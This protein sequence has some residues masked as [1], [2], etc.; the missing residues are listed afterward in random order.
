MTYPPG[1]PNNPP[2]QPP[3]YGQQP[4]VWPY[5]G[6][7]PRKGNKLPFIVAAAV[8]VVAAAILIPVLV[9][10]GTSES[11]NPSVQNVASRFYLGLK[12]HNLSTLQKLGCTPAAVNV[13]DPRGLKLITN[14]TPDRDPV[15][16]D[17]TAAS[18]GM[19]TVTSNGQSS[20]FPISIAYRLTN[21]N[22]CIE[23]VKSGTASA[24]APSSSSSHSLPSGSSSASTASPTCHIPPN[25]TAD[26][27]LV[28]PISIAGALQSYP[29]LPPPV[30]KWRLA[31]GNGT[32][33]STYCFD[34][35]SQAM[36]GKLISYLHGYG[37]KSSPGNV[38][39]QLAF[40]EIGGKPPH[41]FLTVTGTLKV[42]PNNFGDNA[43]SV[44]IDW[45]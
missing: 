30:Y 6:G 42:D 34:G 19:L 1:D 45:R 2:F 18:S 37:Y 27:T 32:P 21:N 39:G 5:Y 36:V 4:P 10:G 14:A 44:E 9:F 25:A 24:P 40:V 28:P 12:T 43:G 23:H 31:Q 8:V 16:A 17:N 3:A 26:P 38:A 20:T 15:V 35:V 7:H 22:W 13:G 11:G 29:R 33:L 41:V